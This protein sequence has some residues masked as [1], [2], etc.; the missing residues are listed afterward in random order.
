M[1]RLGSNAANL[2]AKSQG[3]QEI[4]L[5]TIMQFYDAQRLDLMYHKMMNQVNDIKVL[6][7]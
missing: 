7:C 5:N 3:F 4:Q 2:P 6:V 1:R